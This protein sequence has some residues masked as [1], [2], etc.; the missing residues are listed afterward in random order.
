MD[1]ISSLLGAA[2]GSGITSALPTAKSATTAAS[3]TKSF[4]SVFDAAT[5][6]IDNT[7]SYLQDAQKAEVAFAN[8]ELTSTH[9]LAIIEQKANVSLQYTVAIKNALLSAYKEIMSIQV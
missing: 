8:G 3:G 4:D 9:E 5:K 2:S 1:S 6:L 7:N